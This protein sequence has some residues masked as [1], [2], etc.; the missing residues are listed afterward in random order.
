VYV[1]VIASANG[2]EDRGYESRR[3]VRFL[4]LK[5]LQCCSL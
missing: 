2:T 5:T 1:A 4:G 3:G